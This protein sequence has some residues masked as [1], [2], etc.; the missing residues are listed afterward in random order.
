MA[1]RSKRAQQ[2]LAVLFILIV[3]TVWGTQPLYW[4]LFGPISPTHILAHRIIWSTL[5]LV[6][7]VVAT[8]RGAQLRALT[9]SIQQVVVTFLCAFAI[10]GNWMLNIYAA[11][12]GQVVEA[13]LGHYITP[14]AVVL[15]GVFVLKEPFRRYKMIALAL[16]ALGATIIT[17]H[18]GR[19]PTIAL[20]L[21]VTFVTYS[22]L[23]KTT[24]VGALVGI[25][26]ETV[27]LL[28]F[29][30]L[31][32]LYQRSAGVPF[33]F[34]TATRE[35]L[36]LISTGVFTSI[37]LLLFSIGVRWIDFSNLGFLQYYAPSLSLLIGVLVFHEPFTP[38]Y[39]VSFGFI[40]TAILIVLVA[41]RA[42]IAT[43]EW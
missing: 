27:I 2:R 22:F 6:P 26:A 1:I 28:P 35:I 13:S 29:A 17:V 16:V 41:P 4:R 33:F 23:K 7:I 12:T 21:V 42:T 3:Y 15:L 37:P 40:W 5:L 25:T 20:L 11:A 8:Q 39:F 43:G 34:V 24:P 10:G 14:I 9:G 36:L 31:F 19:L 18:I 30:V 38:V 32:L